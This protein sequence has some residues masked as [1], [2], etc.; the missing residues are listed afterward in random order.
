MEEVARALHMSE[1]TVRRRLRK[2]GTTLRELL[3]GFRHERAV[4]LLS[5]RKYGIA[6][7]AFLL[8]FSE[9]SSF[10]RAFRRWT[11]CTPA[12]FRVG[13]P[14]RA[15]ARPSPPVESLDPD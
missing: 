8:G 10:Y 1:R 11:G 15:A 12:E 13:L 7:V 6:D 2:E 9:L 4:E 5:T 3:D 14:R